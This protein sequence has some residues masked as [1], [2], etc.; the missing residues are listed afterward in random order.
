MAQQFFNINFLTSY[1][2]APEMWL[3][4]A[5]QLVVHPHSPANPLDEVVYLP[6]NGW[7]HR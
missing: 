7:R 6:V 5:M 3:L 4:E 2:S 1:D